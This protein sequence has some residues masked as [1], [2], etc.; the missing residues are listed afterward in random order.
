[1]LFNRRFRW[2]IRD[3][4]PRSPSSPVADFDYH[5]GDTFHQV[6]EQKRLPGP[7]VQ[8][9]AYET[10]ALAPT[11]PVGPGVGIDEQIVPF[12]EPMYAY[13]AVPLQGIGTVAGTFQLQPLF[14]PATGYAGPVDPFVVPPEVFFNQPSAMPNSAA[15]RPVM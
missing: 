10:L 11:T 7:G 2:S 1:M 3:T 13:Q 9:Y 12:H 6:W 15:S 8:N 4:S 14:D 5:P